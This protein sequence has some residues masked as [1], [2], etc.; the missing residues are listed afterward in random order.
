MSEN[1]TEEAKPKLVL[2]MHGFEQELASYVQRRLG[3]AAKP[4]GMHEQKTLVEYA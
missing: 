3:I 1:K 4:L 2:T